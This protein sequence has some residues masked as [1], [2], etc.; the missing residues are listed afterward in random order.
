LKKW[1]IRRGYRNASTTRML[2]DLRY[3]F[4][5]LR[6]NPGFAILAILSIALAI[7]ANSTIFSYADGLLMRPL[8]V[9]NPSQVLT[10]RSVPPTV[11]SLP[12][13]GGGEMS[14]PDIEDFR[15]NNHSFDGLAAYSDVLVTLGRQPGERSQ[16]I[17]A[18]EVNGDFFRALGVEPQL[19]RPFRLD[20][21]EV[22]GRDA[23]AILSHDLWKN[24]FGGR[25]SVIGERVRL[26]GVEFTIIG[27]TPESFTGMDQFLRPGL[28]FPIAM[29]RNLYPYGGGSRT[30]RAGRGLSVKGRLKPGVSRRAAAQEASAIAKGLEQSYPK[31]NT[32][33]GAT[34]S[35]ELEVR[36]LSAPILGGLVAALFSLSIIILLIACANVANLMLVRARARSREI[37]VRLALG[38]A[39]TRVMR[40]LLMESLV[41]A[42]AG[43]AL[44]LLAAQSTSG[45]LSRI[46]L[47]ADVPVRLSFQVDERVLAF[48]ILISV[49]SALLFGLT[50]AI[51]STR[52]DL[53]SVIKLSEADTARK[54]SLGRYAL[55]VVQI[56]GSMILLVATTQGRYE[57]NRLLTGNPGFRTDHR[58]TMR[59]NAAAAGYTD[60]QTVRFYET[61]ARR[62]VEVAGVRSVGLSSGLPMT[63][64]MNTRSVVPDGYEFPRGRQSVEILEYVVDGGYF[65]ALG[66]NLIEGR[67]FNT[68]DRGTS[69][70]VAIVNE[71]FANEYLGPN[72]VG[73]RMHLNDKNGPIVEIVGVTTTGK[74]FSLVE[75]PVHAIYLPLSQNP[76]G[77]M[78]L[79]AEAA[80][81]PQ[82]LAGP[83]QQMIRSIDPNISVFRVRTM[84][85]LFAHSSVNT[86]R[87]VGKVYDAT[88]VM[89]LLL[90]LA[91]LYAVV[92][93]Q[94]SRRTREI[95]IRMALGA[96]RLHV[97]N[98]FLKQGAVMSVAGILGGIMLSR[99]VSRIAADTL[100]ASTNHPVLQVVVSALMFL[101]TLA[102][103][104]IPARRASRI[105]PQ[106]AL[107]EE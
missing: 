107:R 34:V 12:L 80:G 103:A 10:L 53:I 104:V 91:G 5:A 16:S 82:A 26:N 100:G 102:A 8:P 4:R 24:D 96:E 93:Y 89:G 11:S 61:V 95:G 35:T 14:W 56:A 17:L 75:P 41:V 46:E 79:I 45:L 58:L 1:S 7:G 85:D 106:Q 3:V 33:F 67:P 73:K 49:A 70:R 52:Q 31:T 57:F 18:Y 32:G 62:A 74:A 99:Y 40:L 25:A 71:A 76:W 64:D 19:G 54:R 6:Q 83:L 65:N 29:M 77:R 51:H 94:V 38:G 68:T 87:T 15:K 98:I 30:D 22:D 20:E 37:A 86:I 81:D 21:D 84:E 97:M 72:P 92:S 39:R 47:P 63:F 105:A 55:V 88:A 66:V 13:R 101:T 44:A 23:V 50:P 69:P 2:N 9:A 36:I 59:F 60:E 90:A 42:L 48:T 27:V 43:G 78:T 28:F